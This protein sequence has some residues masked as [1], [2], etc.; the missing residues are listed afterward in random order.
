MDFEPIDLFDELPHPRSDWLCAISI[1]GYTIPSASVR[2]FSTSNGVIYKMNPQSNEQSELKQAM[3]I[4]GYI[5]LFVL[6][7]QLFQGKVSGFIYVN[8]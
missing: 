6:V 5:L 8:F 3:M 7:L 2:F 1:L 4:M